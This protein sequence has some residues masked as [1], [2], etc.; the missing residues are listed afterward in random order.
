M[1]APLLVLAF[2]SVIIGLFPASVM[3]RLTQITVGLF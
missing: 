1:L 3:E 2:L